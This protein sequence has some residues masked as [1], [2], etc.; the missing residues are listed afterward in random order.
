VWFSKAD[1]ARLAQPYEL[2]PDGPARGWDL[3]TYDGDRMLRRYGGFPGFHAQISLMPDRGLAIAVL[4]NGGAASVGVADLV[5]AYA[6]DVLLAKPSAETTSEAR[7]KMWS[8]GLQDFRAKLAAE[9]AARQARQQPTSL[10]LE[11]YAGTYESPTFG[12]MVLTVDGGRLKTAMGVARSDAEVHD[13]SAHQFRVELTGG[14]SLV[15]FQVPLTASRPASLRFM[16]ETFT[17][18]R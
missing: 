8:E 12:R 13:A 7:W 6:Y 14:G 16:N 18:V 5:T 15:T 17:R 10:A 3:A 4:T 1:P 11:D 9:L 2:G